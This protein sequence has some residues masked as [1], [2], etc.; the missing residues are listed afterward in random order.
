MVWGSCQQ[1]SYSF[2]KYLS[3]IHFFSTYK[4]MSATVSMDLLI[5]L[6]HEH[7]ITFMLVMIILQFNVFVISK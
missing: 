5:T 7:G 3:L 6:R 2:Y 1:H 4:E